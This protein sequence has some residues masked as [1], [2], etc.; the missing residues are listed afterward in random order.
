MSVVACGPL[1]LAV[2]AVTGPEPCAREELALRIVAPFDGREVEALQKAWNERAV[3]W[4]ARARF[5]RLLEPTRSDLAGDTLVVGYEEG[6]LA[7]LA[8]QGL[9]AGAPSAFARESWAPVWSVAAGAEPAACKSFRALADGDFGGRVRLRRP[10]AEST[11]G[12]L[13]G[14]VAATLGMDDDVWLRSLV[15]ASDEAATLLPAG[16]SYRELLRQLPAGA[17]LLAPLR[18]A[19]LVQ[20]E[21]GSLE[22]GRPEE[23][24]VS[25]TLAAA[26]GREASGLVREWFTRRFV[27]DVA[28]RLRATIELE[29][30]D[31]P[32]ADAP[33]WQQRIAA[34][35]LPFD[36]AAAE[37][38]RDRIVPLYGAAEEMAGGS[39]VDIAEWIIDG[40]LLTAA[41]LFV[42]VVARRMGGRN[43]R[44]PRDG[45]VV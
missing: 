15:L 31:A 44:D 11:E 25:F 1:L 22:W 6:R 41:L 2:V 42:V 5:T 24:F 43:D 18:V 39:A 17:V 45:A 19:T 40:A 29:P 37:Q 8:G 23:G 13:L 12:L 14:V 36:R 20:R 4:G 32:G 26:P 9:L 34:A 27:T 7:A 30:L 10:T 28:P 33:A 21:G 38:L 3:E 16:R 35:P